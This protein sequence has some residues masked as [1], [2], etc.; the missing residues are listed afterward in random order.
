MKSFKSLAWLAGLVALAFASLA[1]GAP[2]H[3]DLF[4]DG[5]IGFA[6][7][8]MLINKQNLSNV[9]ISLKTTFNN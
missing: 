4:A 1:F 8:G 7:G 2:V 9:F 5:G 3:T 6:M